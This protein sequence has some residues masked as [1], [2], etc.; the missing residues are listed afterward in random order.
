[1]LLVPAVWRGPA[2]SLD[3]AGIVIDAGI[4]CRFKIV[5]SKGRSFESRRSNE[6]LK[7]PDSWKPFDVS[8]SAQS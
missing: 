3:D 2:P 8:D 7:N 4:A 5:G 6:R 1:V